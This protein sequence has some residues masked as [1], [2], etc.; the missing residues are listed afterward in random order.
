MKGKEMKIVAVVAMVIVAVTAV[1][2]VRKIEV[3][4]TL[5][6]RLDEAVWSQ[7]DWETGFRRFRNAE[8]GRV[9]T[10]QTEFAILGDSEAIYVGVKA[11]HKKMAEV[12]AMGKSPIWSSESVELYFGPD[13]ETFDFYQFLVTFQ[14]LN[15]AIF[16]S[17]GG[18]IKPDPYAPDWEAKT[19]ETPEGWTA[20]IRIPLGAFYMTRGN[21]WKDTWKLNVARMYRD[22]GGYDCNCWIDGDGF[23]DLKNFKTMKDFPIRRAAEDVWVKSAVASVKGP[24]DGRLCGTLDFV[25]YVAKAGPFMLTSDFTDPVEAQLKTGDNKLTVPAHFPE[26][27]R[28]SLRIVLTRTDGA[29]VCKRTYPVLVDYCPI[30]LGF[31]VPSYRGNFYPGQNS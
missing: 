25:V 7:A 28:H 12:K 2:D 10:A 9:P 5:D 13:G 20:E 15:H 11:H 24:E 18:N 3:K 27:G 23:R 22:A 16:Y 4:P 6:G 1:A 30:R 8:R 14:G 31:T 17:E 19:V 29:A 26:N 21:A